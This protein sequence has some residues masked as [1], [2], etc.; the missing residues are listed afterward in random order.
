M[1]KYTEMTFSDLRKAC[2]AQG[3]SAAGTKDELVARLEGAEPTSNPAAPAPIVSEVKAKEVSES[4]VDREY[5]SDKEKVK[6]RLER[7][8]K[9]RTFIPIDQG[10]SQEVA[11]KIPFVVNINGY[12]VEIKRG[13]YVD[14]PMEIADMIRERL[15]SEGKIGRQH[16]LSSDAARQ[17]ALS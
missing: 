12:R 11:E 16:L 14:V 5:R 9:I 13:T 1:S 10:V 8:P 7:Q 6:A 2:S 15:E 4:A 3:L 17:Q